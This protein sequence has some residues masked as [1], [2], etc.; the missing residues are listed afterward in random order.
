MTLEVQAKTISPMLRRV[1]WNKGNLI[2]QKPPLRPKH[3]WSIRTRRQMHGLMI[4]HKRPA[5]KMSQSQHSAPIKQVTVLRVFTLV[6]LMRKILIR[7]NT[8]NQ[9]KI[10]FTI[11]RIVSEFNAL[12]KF[13]TCRGH[14]Q[15]DP[16]YS[17]CN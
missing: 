4:P 10:T 6:F 16:V 1:P 15:W 14:G 17:H 12:T 3:V 7:K 11:R 5:P 2:G 13:T 9:I 8:Y